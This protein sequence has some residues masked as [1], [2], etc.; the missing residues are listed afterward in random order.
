M[1]APILRE[2]AHH[3]YLREQLVAAFPDA[4]E[5]TLKDTLEGLTDLNEMVAALTRSYLEDRCLASGLRIRLGEMQERVR[6]FDHAG[7]TKRQILAKVMCR[8]D[9]AKTIEPD[10]TLSLRQGQPGLVVENEDRIPD[11]Y[12]KQQLLKLDRQGLLAAL[13]TGQRVPGVVLTNGAPSITVRT[14]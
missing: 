11:E 5:E 4:D 8:A 1:T 14:K 3:E 6:R 7:E 13:K 2:L 9:L 12:W 10:F